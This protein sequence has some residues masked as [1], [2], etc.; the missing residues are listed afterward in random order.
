MLAL[1]HKESSAIVGVVEL[2]MQPCDGK[3][4]GDVRLPRPPWASEPA[5]AVKE[6][7]YISN[8]AVRSTW[9]NRGMGAS[10]LGACEQLTRQDWGFEEVYLHAATDKAK[11]LSMYGARGYTQLPEMDQP[12]WVLALSGREATRYH[13]KAL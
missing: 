6:V 5:V 8:L 12:G 9:R 10:L 1:Q 2:M 11:L 13:R 4:P 7:P 3:V